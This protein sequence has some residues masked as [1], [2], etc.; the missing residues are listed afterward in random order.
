MVGVSHDHAEKC[1][2]CD[3]YTQTHA[4]SDVMAVNVEQSHDSA[5]CAGCKIITPKCHLWPSFNPPH[6]FVGLLS[7]QLLFHGSM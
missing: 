2:M 5:E 3:E 7:A 1:L 4:H 6:V